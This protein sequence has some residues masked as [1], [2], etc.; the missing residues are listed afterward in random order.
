MDR[1][2]LF[3][4]IFCLVCSILIFCFCLYEIRGDIGDGLIRL[5]TIIGAEQQEDVQQQEIQQQGVQQQGQ[6]RCECG[7]CGN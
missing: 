4:F 3:T 2:W 6:I 5:G 1:S 7:C